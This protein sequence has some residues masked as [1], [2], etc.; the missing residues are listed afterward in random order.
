MQPP[1]DQL[2]YKLLLAV[3]AIPLVGSVINV[4]VGRHLPRRGDWL[5]SGGRFLVMCITVY[6]FA[7]VATGA[8]GFFHESVKESGPSYGWLYHEGA[9]PSH[10]NIVAGILYDPLGAT[11]LAVVGI[12]SFFV[13][14]F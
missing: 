2:D 14:L 7:K 12:V 3:L 4:F 5:L 9:K 1:L 11:M 10:L 13:H 8:G 6:L